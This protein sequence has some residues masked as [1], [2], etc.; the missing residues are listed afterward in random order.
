MMTNEI[1]ALAKKMDARLWLSS[2][3]DNDTI[4]VL[5][6]ALLRFPGHINPRDTLQPQLIALTHKVTKCALMSLTP[7]ED[8]PNNLFA[9][10][11]LAVLDPEP[12]PIRDDLW[13]TVCPCECIKKTVTSGEKKRKPVPPAPRPVVAA[14]IPK[15]KKRLP[16]A[17]PAV[18]VAKKKVRV[19][20]QEQE[21]EDDSTA[22]LAS[23]YLMGQLLEAEFDSAPGTHGYKLEIEVLVLRIPDWIFQVKEA[24][25]EHVGLRGDGAARAVMRQSMLSCL[26]ILADAMYYCSKAL[27]YASLSFVEGVSKG[28]NTVQAM[29][30]DLYRAHEHCRGVEP[31]INSFRFIESGVFEDV[32]VK[33]KGVSD[34]T[35][36][37]AP[38]KLLELPKPVASMNTF[39]LLKR[40]YAE[41]LRAHGKLNDMWP[42]DGLVVDWDGHCRAVGELKDILFEGMQHCSALLDFLR[43]EGTM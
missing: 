2:N 19:S 3:E 22:L 32:G 16:D 14:P 15:S 40:I 34:S 17:P 42:D 11:I 39:N 43:M 36:T 38:P 6:H 37:E 7:V 5:T 30:D 1:R 8:V 21:E 28:H 23:G 41:M 24:D 18:V 27:F 26:K 9:D 33:K 10:A 29:H 35:T 12:S 25:H 31:V 20:E 4:G 13:R